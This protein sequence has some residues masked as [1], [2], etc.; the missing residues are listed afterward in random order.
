MILDYPVEEVRYW[1]NA[2]RCHSMI[3]WRPM[4]TQTYIKV[5]VMTAKE[6]LY[7][8]RLCFFNDAFVAN[9]TIMTMQILSF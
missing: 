3:G 2:K 8:W 4:P 7:M 6:D 1:N 9:G 5:L